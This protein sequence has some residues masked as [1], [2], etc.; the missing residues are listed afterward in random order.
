MNNNTLIIGSVGILSLYYACFILYNEDS[1]NMMI[2]INY[3]QISLVVLFSM[4]VAV[5]GSYSSY[6]SLINYKYEKSIQFNEDAII[7]EYELD[8]ME[9]VQYEEEEEEEEDEEE[10]DINTFITPIKTE[11]V[12]LPIKVHQTNYKVR[13]M[14]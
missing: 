6:K 7:K 11:E 2:Y 3:G 10:E 9:D 13:L 4:F 8:Q 14:V 12:H 5:L 1:P